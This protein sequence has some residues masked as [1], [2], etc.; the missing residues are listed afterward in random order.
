[1]GGGRSTVLL[2]DLGEATGANRSRQQRTRGDR[3]ERER[4]VGAGRSD[5]RARRTDPPPP[6]PHETSAAP[7]TEE[8]TAP[9]I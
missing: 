8:K 2:L 7:H 1:M 5:R 3:S 9:T 6:R 4:W